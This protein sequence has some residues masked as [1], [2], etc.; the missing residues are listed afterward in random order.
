MNL[1]TALLCPDCEASLDNHFD[2]VDCPRCAT[3]L[4]EVLEVCGYGPGQG[5]G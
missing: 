2:A 3:R 1:L 5:V 4:F